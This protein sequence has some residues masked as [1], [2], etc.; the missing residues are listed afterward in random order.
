MEMSKQTN[1]SL[2]LII[3]F[4]YLKDYYKDTILNT[5]GTPVFFWTW[6]GEYSH[7]KLSKLFFFTGGYKHKAKY[8]FDSAFR[9]L[10]YLKYFFAPN[11]LFDTA[12]VGLAE[13]E[14]FKPFSETLNPLRQSNFRCCCWWSSASALTTVPIC[15]NWFRPLERK[16]LGMLPWFSLS[17]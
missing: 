12:S 4:K 14:T 6:T 11:K 15:N 5:K 16:A 2:P 10:L 1:L 17:Q 7:I 13:N 8:A 3:E 9:L